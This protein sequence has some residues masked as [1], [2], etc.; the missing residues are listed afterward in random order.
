MV[1]S[2]F[3]LFGCNFNL[4]HIL[5]TLVVF[6]YLA[7]FKS[8]SQK[9]PGFE[10]LPPSSNGWSFGG[11][12][13]TTGQ[14]GVRTGLNRLNLAAATTSNQAAQHTTYT[15]TVP[16]SG[17]NHV[18]VIGWYRRTNSSSAVV[19]T[20]ARGAST[21]N[22]T[23]E[24]EPSG[25]W[26]Q[27]TASGVA[28][29]GG[30]Y[31]PVFS[32]QGNS[33]AAYAF[34]DIIIYT[35]TS[36]GADITA[37]NAPT[38]LCVN[39]SGSD[40]V[41]TWTNGTDDATNSSG[42]SGTLILRA[43]AGTALLSQTGN[44]PTDLNNQGYYN[45]NSDIGP[46]TIGAWSVLED[47]AVSPFTDYSAA[48]GDYVY[49]VYM[50]DVAFNYSPAISFTTSRA[51]TDQNLACNTLNATL[52]AT[53]APA[54]Y[55]GTWSV[56]SGTGTFGTS[57]SNTSTVT[58][59]AA[60]NN[61]FRWTVSN[62]ACSTYNDVIVAASTA[63]PLAAVPTSPTNGA[64][65][66][67]S[68]PS[69]NLNW[70]NGGGT[71]SYN[72]YFGTV[73][74]GVL[75]QSNVTLN[76][77]G[78]GNLNPNTTYYWRIDAVNVC[79]TTTGTVQ[80]FTT[81]PNFSNTTAQACGTD[82]TNTFGNFTRN[83]TVSG[84]PTPLG[85]GAGQYVLNQIDIR[86]GSPSCMKDLRTY[87][88]RLTAPDGTVLDFIDNLTTTAND[89]WLNAKFRD[90]SALE[91]ISQ[92]ATTTQSNFYPY[93]IG[94]YAVETDGSFS[95]FN[96]INPNGTWVL[97]IKEAA[98]TGTEIS[99]VS[100]TLLFGPQIQVN[101]L[102]GNSAN[103]FCSGAT[104]LDLSSVIVGSN[105]GYSSNDPFFP[106]TTVDGC[107]WNGA[108]NNSAWFSFIASATTAYITLSGIANPSTSASSDTQPIVLV[109]PAGGCATPTAVPTGGCPDDATRNNLSY[110]AANGGGAGTNPY[111][112]GITTNTE[113]NL[114]GLTVGQKYFLYVDGNGGISSSFYI[115]ATRG[116]QTICNP[117]LSII[118]Y[119]FK[120]LNRNN[121]NEL[122]ITIN[123]ESDKLYYEIEYSL[124]GKDFEMI[125]NYTTNSQ[126]DLFV[127]NHY[128]K[129]EELFQK[130]HYYRLKF[131]A[132]K[133]VYYS[134][135]ISIEKKNQLNYI[136]YPNPVKDKLYIYTLSTS[137]KLSCK[138][139]NL[140]G[141]L[142][143][144]EHIKYIS[145]NKIELDL[146]NL[147][148]GVYLIKIEND[149][150]N[151]YTKFVKD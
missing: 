71:I 76:N 120:G 26:N 134:K 9:N 149:D 37:P 95:N 130:I 57:N 103:N 1:N 106:G 83:I 63:S 110:L 64:T 111:S 124:N 41:L 112:N 118:D 36:S 138:I 65:N 108:N 52:A 107:S 27:V 53:A 17:T 8:Y 89:V 105:N 90:H 99:F 21:I 72:V 117:P 29:N 129:D 86:L 66:I 79:G 58:G 40:N 11:S 3:M 13:W 82:F 61:I 121:M 139:F 140:H 75:I 91:K 5:A 16:S 97:S 32:A 141:Q 51:G 93:S 146:E 144:T 125:E 113:F 142:V 43:P 92:Y 131:Y 85:T 114:S 18:H 98:A 55:T 39:T 109:A 151:N 10:L 42:I 81:L 104:C 126:K 116:L 74:P 49:A 69:V 2:R 46:N 68:S 67:A 133:N 54:G 80:S 88:F 122:E 35:S 84:L 19:R 150:L 70:N 78:V 22:G 143:L 128:L 147:K 34:E 115:E 59:L 73:S 31:Y 137:N 77:F 23:L 136:M 94:Y 14:S 148:S 50:R 45:L 24:A 135:I 96:G 20:E 25:Q 145:T 15:I 12:G 7:V 60:G 4:R 30:T 47:S 38:N 33:T 62:G 100:V 132:N 44:A 28:T 48:G 56:V 123:N 119:G 101:D 102:I 6:S 127:F 87:D